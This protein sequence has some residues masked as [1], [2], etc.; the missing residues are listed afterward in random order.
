M[1]T[2]KPVGLHLDEEIIAYFK[3]IANETGLSYQGL[4]NFFLLEA[5]KMKWCGS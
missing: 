5:I 4:I 3:K 2:K 1:R